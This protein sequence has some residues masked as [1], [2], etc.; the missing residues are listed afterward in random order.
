MKEKIFNIVITGASNGLGNFLA[1][2]LSLEGHNVLGIG[3]RERSLAD[4]PD[5]IKYLQ[6]D[7][8]HILL[9]STNKR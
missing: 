7:L 8:S 5:S 6:F 3:R 2:K 1:Q 4:L 9:E